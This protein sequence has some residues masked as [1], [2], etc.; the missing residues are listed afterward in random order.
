MEGADTLA[1]IWDKYMVD[2][3]VSTFRTGQTLGGR[4]ETSGDDNRISTRAH[5]RTYTWG[6]G[7]NVRKGDN[8]PSTRAHRGRSTWGGGR[9]LRKAMTISPNHYTRAALSSSG[10]IFGEAPFSGQMGNEALYQH[11]G[12]IS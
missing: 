10:L 2:M 3:A 7:K 5:R 1:L 6:T 4:E 11:E 9:N 8:C 12:T